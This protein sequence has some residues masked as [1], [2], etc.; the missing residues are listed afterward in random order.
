MKSKL[1]YTLIFVIFFAGCNSD[2][3]TKY[4]ARESLRNSQPV[5]L[6]RGFVDLCYAENTGMAFSLLS[7]LD[8]PL[9]RGLLVCVPLVTTI[10][11][12]LFIWRFRVKHFTA[13][14]PFAFILAGAAGNILDRIRYGHVVDFIHFHVRDIFHW[15]IFNIAD[16]LVFVG[17]LMLFLQ[18]GFR[19]NTHINENL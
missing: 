11:F 8:P 13:L 15:P 1:K 4:M 7:Y 5:I 18:Y 2:Q 19:K 16:V 14:L 10:C 12:S 17:G 3:R 9:R 6:L